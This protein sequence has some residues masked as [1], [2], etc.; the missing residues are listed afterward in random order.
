MKRVTG[1]SRLVSPVALLVAASIVATAALVGAAASPGSAKAAATGQQKFVLYSVTN[2][3]QFLDHSDDRARGKGNNPFGNFKDSKT[4]T[5]EAGNG[6]FPGDNAVFSFALYTNSNLKSQRRL[7]DLHL[8][9]QLQQARLLRR[10][11]PAQQRRPDRSR[12]LRLQRRHVR[13]RD[14]GRHRQIR[15]RHRRHLS[16]TG[17]ETRTAPR[18]RHRLVTLKR[19]RR[20]GRPQSASAPPVR[21]EHPY[22]FVLQVPAFQL[23][24]T[25]TGFTRGPS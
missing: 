15:R 4:T 13:G 18:L 5:K 9:L 8:H 16:N 19:I 2:E 21:L 6:P 24:V 11:L 1:S 10:L 17:R 23:A 20:D 3:E 25:S 14:H 7:G 12:R 22:S